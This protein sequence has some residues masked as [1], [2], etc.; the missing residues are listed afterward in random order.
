MTPAFCSD[1]VMLEQFRAVLG[2]GFVLVLGLLLWEYVVYYTKPVKTE[3][4]NFCPLHRTSRDEC[5]SKH[6]ED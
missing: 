2:I 3:K 6:N 1:P 4:P 5:E